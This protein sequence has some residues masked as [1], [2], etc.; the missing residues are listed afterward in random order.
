MQRY[1]SKIN[2]NAPSFTENYVQMQNA[3]NTLTEKLHGFAT[4]EGSQRS[5]DR[6]LKRGKLRAR[7]RIDS[8]L[9]EDSPF[10]ELMTLSGHE[11]GKARVLCGIGIIR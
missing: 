5:I 4:F 8:L 3:V 1:Q 10:M 6:H 2:P 11:P 9:D 7:S